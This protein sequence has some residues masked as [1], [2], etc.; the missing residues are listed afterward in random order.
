[1][2]YIYLYFLKTFG[3]ILFLK[4]DGGEGWGVRSGLS[5]PTSC[6]EGHQRDVEVR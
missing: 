2:M 5:G 3:L 1:M 4:T 6:G